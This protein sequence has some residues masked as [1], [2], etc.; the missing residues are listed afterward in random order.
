MTPKVLQQMYDIAT[1]D[2]YGSLFMDMKNNKFYR[3]F[4]SELKAS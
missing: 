2:P 3:S 4:T 1:G